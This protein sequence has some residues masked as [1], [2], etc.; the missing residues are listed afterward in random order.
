MLCKPS[1][2]LGLQEVMAFQ[3]SRLTS[4][5]RWTQSA[6]EAGGRGLVPWAPPTVFQAR[7]WAK[8]CENI[9]FSVL[10]QCSRPFDYAYYYGFNFVDFLFLLVGSFFGYFHSWFSYWS[11]VS[12]PCG[13]SKLPCF[14][15]FPFH[16]QIF[17]W[18]M[19]H[20][21]QLFLF[22]TFTGDSAFFPCVGWAN[23]FVLGRHWF[24]SRWC[25]VTFAD[26]FTCSQL[27]VLCLVLMRGNEDATRKG[28]VRLHQ[29]CQRM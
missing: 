23:V 4:F 12:A 29:S 11:F 6:E 13:L 24:P 28:V 27:C 14:L 18:T 5:S 21:L 1:S 22:A 20:P 2:G 8:E 19:F 17:S 25:L 26:K 15:G 3:L 9:S 16:L 10:C 7:L